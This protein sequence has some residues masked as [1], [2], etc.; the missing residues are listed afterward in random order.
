LKKS[1]PIQTSKPEKNNK[2]P[3]EKT[4]ESS[5]ERKAEGLQHGKKWKIFILTFGMLF[6]M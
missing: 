1:I 5:K 4:P 2:I 6:K 3:R